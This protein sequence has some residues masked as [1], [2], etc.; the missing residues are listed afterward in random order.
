ME[1]APAT[2]GAIPA[3]GRRESARFVPLGREWAAELEA[4]FGAEVREEVL[5]RAADAGRAE[6]LA[7]LDPASV[8]PSIELL[9]SV[10]SL[11]GG[12]P[13]QQLTRL[14]P[15]VKRLVDELARQLATR[16][17]PAMTGLATPRPTRRPG[18]PLDLSRTLRA[19]L[20]HT[21]RLADGR[22][23]VVPSGRSSAPAP[24]ARPTGG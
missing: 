20:A 2:S 8:R 13:E 15:L 3:A 24:D 16:L 19:N 11:A 17:R 9:T 6:V 7:E 14:R 23:V 1:K 21:R 4:L 10:L 5:G 22:T 12:L 18:G